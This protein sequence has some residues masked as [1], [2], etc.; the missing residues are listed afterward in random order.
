MAVNQLLDAP[1]PVGAPH[2]SCLLTLVLDGLASILHYIE[3]LH[4]SLGCL[5]PGGELP[6]LHTS[7]WRE[8]T[9]P[10]QVRLR[11]L[12]FH[13]YLDVV[14][15][16]VQ[17][18]LPHIHDRRCAHPHR[19]HIV[20]PRVVSAVR[21]WPVEQ[22]E[23]MV[24]ILRAHVLDHV[25]VE[26]RVHDHFINDCARAAEASSVA[27]AVLLRGDHAS[28]EP[29][30][31][32]RLELLVGV[33]LGGVRVGQVA[34]SLGVDVAWGEGVDPGLPG[35]LIRDF[36]VP[37][38]VDV[39]G[40]FALDIL[41]ERPDMVHGPELVV[42]EPDIRVDHGRLEEDLPPQ[43]LDPASP[44]GELLGVLPNPVIQ[45]LVE[46]DELDCVGVVTLELGQLPDQRREVGALV[47]QPLARD[48]CL[49]VLVVEIK[50]GHEAPPS[51][52]VRD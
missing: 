19:P 38:G 28:A 1:F 33:H 51:D 31:V 35:G 6:I 2:V 8:S 12:V 17:V 52:A 9:E 40:E 4:V 5:E 36:D 46:R 29:E 27:L 15:V 47:V 41:Q 10:A 43:R 18:S 21:V 3:P 39:G 20:E 7:V 37:Q 30:P 14:R 24:V 44:F 25:F 49:E 32:L 50:Q 22:H 11:I 16:V 48:G 23:V 34:I 45:G 26:G 13:G 42:H